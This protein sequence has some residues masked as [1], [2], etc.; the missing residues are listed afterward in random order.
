MFCEERAMA[1]LHVSNVTQEEIAFD[2]LKAVEPRRPGRP[3]DEIDCGRD[4]VEGEKEQR[5]WAKWNRDPDEADTI[6]AWVVEVHG[7]DYKFMLL[8]KPAQEREM[9]LPD[10]IVFDGAVI[11]YGNAHRDQSRNRMLSCRIMGP[12]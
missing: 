10:R 4:D 6:W 1:E 9:A 8:A 2:E 7:E 5:Q 11:E 3:P 12:A